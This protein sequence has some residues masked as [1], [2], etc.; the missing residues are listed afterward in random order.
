M[1]FCNIP[2]MS[3]TSPTNHKSVYGSYLSH[4]DYSGSARAYTSMP[5]LSLV[6]SGIQRTYTAKET[7]K[8]QLPITPAILL[9]LKEYRTPQ[10]SDPDIIMAWAAAVL[11]FFDIFRAGDI[12]TSHISDF[13]AVSTWHGEMWQLMMAVTHSY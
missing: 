9:K 12:T 5:Q 4:A 8:I 6:Q 1:L 10:K 11:C 3:A 7:A 2:G 13:T